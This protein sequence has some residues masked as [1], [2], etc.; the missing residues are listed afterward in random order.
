MLKKG[1]NVFCLIV[2]LLIIG[3]AFVGVV[4]AEEI[5]I[6]T[7]IDE[8]SFIVYP[9]RPIIGW[10][11]ILDHDTFHTKAY[12]GNFWY[13]LCG[14]E[15]HEYPLY[16][17]LWQASLPQSGDYEVFVWIPDPDPFDWQPKR[18]Y[19]PTQSAVYQIYHKAGRRTTKTVNQE[20]MTGGFCSL[21]T[22]NFDTLASVILDDRTGESYLSTMIA[23]D[24]VKFVP[25]AAPNQPPNTPTR[26]LKEDLKK[27]VFLKVEVKLLLMLKT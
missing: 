9:S 15:G 12:N 14:E 3:S 18:R 11:H 26:K 25:V 21:G 10:Y 6:D 27:V 22:F 4:S 2:I 24:A 13:T 16:Y 8:S 23:F 17:G 20:L 7:E 19:T 5:I 1:A